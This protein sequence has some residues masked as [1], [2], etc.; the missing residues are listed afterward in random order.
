[1]SFLLQAIKCTKEVVGVHSEGKYNIL[2]S[3][4]LSFYLL[5]NLAV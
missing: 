2:T 5:I 1:M 3:A 4:F